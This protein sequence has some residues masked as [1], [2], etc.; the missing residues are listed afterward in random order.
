MLFSA[1]SPLNAPS[2]WLSRLTFPLFD[3][4]DRSDRM[5]ELDRLLFSQYWPRRVLEHAQL[6]A[7]KRA[8]AYATTHV[9]YYAAHPRWNSKEAANIN[10]LSDLSLFPILTKA[11]VRDFNESLTTE[12]R[13]LRDALLSTKTGGSTG[14]SL[15]L[16]FNHDAQQHRNAAAMRSD[17][18]AGWRPG[19]WTGCLWGS[20]AY[21]EGLKQ[22]LRNVLRD[23]LVYL[24]TMRL[25]EVS[26]R[27]FLRSMQRKHM[28]ALFG[29]AHSLYI[30]ADFA[31]KNGIRVP[32]P[33]AIVSTSM[34]L[35]ASERARIEEAFKCKVTD[36][37]GCEEVGLIASECE[38]HSGYHVCA[39]HIIVEILDEAGRPCAPGEIGRVIVTDLENR[40]MP[41][42]RYEVGDLAAWAKT[43]CPCGR[44]L[45]TL[46]RIVGRQADCLQR[47]DGSLVAG[48]SLVER[49][50][51][52]IE[53]LAQLQL[54]QE[55]ERTLR[56]Y[57]VL[58]SGASQEAV[59]RALSD[60]LGKDLG[61]DIHLDID[62]VARIP[63]EKNG[64]YRFAIRRF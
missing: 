23:R 62:V 59:T 35:L 51:L 8:I 64:K 44:G 18:W 34:M 3:L 43:P 33:H 32:P 17:M 52:A 5:Q 45:P 7:L 47:T 40:G 48:V 53:G 20:P 60:A 22:R 50:L 31:L 24:D 2:R 46:E 61:A 36:R 19:D 4:Y 1:D 57:A 56:A 30:L 49:T 42:F 37:Y 39:E 41:L 26:M 55:S 15:S 28:D 11:Q 16:K 54:V 21:P 25:D 14:T 58:S 10:A 12:E 6:K 27:T 9:P 29:H 38:Q 63:Q 13:P